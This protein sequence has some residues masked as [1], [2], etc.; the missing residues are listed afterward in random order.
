MWYSSTA[1]PAPED[2]TAR[3]GANICVI[4]LGLRVSIHVEN[5]AVL[6]ALTRALGEIRAAMDAQD[7]RDQVPTE[8]ADWP[9]GEI[10]EVFGR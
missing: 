8:M 3:T 10:A 2:V 5:R 9:P 4:D 6:D 7:A 1:I